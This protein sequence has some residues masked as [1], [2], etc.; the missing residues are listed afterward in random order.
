MAK[1]K[2][3]KPQKPHS[4]SPQSNEVRDL[5]GQT[6]VNIDGKIFRLP[7]MAEMVQGNR[8]IY[9]KINSIHENYYYRSQLDPFDAK[10]NATR[11]AAGQKLEYLAI[12][13]GKNK[14]CT[15]NFDY[16]AGIPNGAEFFNIFKI[17][18][19]QEF[20]DALKHTK[21]LQSILWDVI[22]DNKPA[23]HRRMDKYREGLDLLIDYWKL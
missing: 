15:M 12:I 23:T 19:E 11:F 22:V 6:L 7:D 18:H 1:K 2:K 5:G 4:K 16:L 14:S 3:K 10:K 21:Q 20:N 17:D 13:S 8:Y 9:K